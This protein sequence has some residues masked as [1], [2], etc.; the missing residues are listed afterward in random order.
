MKT[1]NELI[2]KG[3]DFLKGIKST[4]RV[5]IFSH[6]DMDGMASAILLND[7]LVGKVKSLEVF[8][9]S[10]YKPGE[11]PDFSKFDVVITSDL[12]SSL[13]SAF[14]E[15]LKGKRV[16]YIDH[17]PPRVS[18]P[19]NFVAVVGESWNSCSKMIY[20]IFGGK[21]W[22]AV[23]GALNDA[24]EKSENNTEFLQNFLKKE[25]LDIKTFG[26]DFAFKFSLML[27]YVEPALKK[28]FDILKDVK[29]YKEINNL[30][31]YIVP[32]QKE[33]DET[34]KDFEKNKEIINGV[35]FFV[36]E[37]HYGIKSYV[38]NRLSINSD[39]PFIFLTPLEDNYRISFREQSKKLDG[40]KVLN[41]IGVKDAGGH[42]AAC[43]GTIK[44][45]FLEKLKKNLSEFD[46]KLAEIKN[47]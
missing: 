44:Q 22:L 4:D 27:I 20:E 6:D 26:M 23:V 5:A 16:L 1:S 11:E 37:P 9:F 18:L 24:A 31:K 13:V 33:I 42:A 12:A 8:F 2:K 39:K 47:G 38:I 46:F 10:Y 45:T 25:K 43:G 35:V 14:F 21:E 32:V 29:N 3:N 7:V 36:F 41:G 30:S 34:I 28:A 19:S 15:Q 17:H 40:V